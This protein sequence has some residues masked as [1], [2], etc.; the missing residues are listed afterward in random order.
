MSE[1]KPDDDG[2]RHVHELADF[3]G[4]K[5]MTIEDGG[6]M[7]P[8]IGLPVRQGQALMPGVAV[9]KIETDPE[10]GCGTITPIFEMPSPPSS[11]AGPA[12]SS[13]PAYRKGWDAIKWN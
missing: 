9:S 5:I 8:A 11:H 6:R 3:G 1:K 13:S 10:T 12:R 4:V 2:S 7:R